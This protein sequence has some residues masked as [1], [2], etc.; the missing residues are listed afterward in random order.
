M[1]K[2]EEKGRERANI[3]IKK[4]K[5]LKQ[6]PILLQKKKRNCTRKRKHQIKLKKTRAIHTHKRK[7]RE[8]KGNNKNNGK[9]NLI[10]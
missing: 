8:R 10:R 7:E 6:V 2:G 4:F 9:Q 5:N 3:I 1:R